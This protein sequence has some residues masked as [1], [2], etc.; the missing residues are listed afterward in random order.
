MTSVVG[1]SPE[2]F[3]TAAEGLQSLVLEVEGSGVRVFGLLDFDELLQDIIA[4]V[5]LA[6][7]PL[8]NSPG[9]STTHLLNATTC[10]AKS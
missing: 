1:L 8:V 10:S 2:A 6:A 5:W 4:L 9:L 7:A 3:E